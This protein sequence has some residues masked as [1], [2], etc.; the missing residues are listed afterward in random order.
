MAR[1]TRR[2]FAIEPEIGEIIDAL[3]HDHTLEAN[4][5]VNKALRRYLEWGRFVDGFKLVT[6]DPRLYKLFWSHLT[7]DEARDMG[8]QN[9][10]NNV[11]EFVL[12]YYHKFDLDSVLKIFK[13]IGAEYS[14]VYA[15]AESG[16]SDNRTIILRHGMGRSASAYYG[17]SLKALCDRL[18]MELE[19]EESEDQLVCKILGAEKEK[20]VVQNRQRIIAEQSTK[21][22][23]RRP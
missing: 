23:I 22:T 21:S 18:G 20:S 19:L 13:V 10:N 5:L 3:T 9:G 6:I 12:S 8:L 15:Y 7:V 17:A 14:N 11:V 1:L 4:L 2:T 16:D